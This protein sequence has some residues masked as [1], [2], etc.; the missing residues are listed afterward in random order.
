MTKIANPAKNFNYSIVFGGVEVA[1]AQSVDVG[2]IELAI[3]K[4]GDGADTVKT[5]G[6][7][8]GP[9]ITIENLISVDTQEG[10]D[11]IKW[12]KKVYD[13]EKSEHGLPSDYKKDGF[14]LELAPDKKTA[15]R[16]IQVEEAFTYSIT[17]SKKG[18]LEEGNSMDTVILATKKAYYLT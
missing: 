13:F 8:E 3:D 11:F 9:D 14:I 15:L 18:D 4:H 5:A 2:T 6:R 16:T 1:T 17:P 12:M 7:N 10:R